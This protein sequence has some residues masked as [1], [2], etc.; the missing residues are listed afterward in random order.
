MVHIQKR[1]GVNGTDSTEFHGATPTKN[2]KNFAFG[3]IVAGELRKY[4]NIFGQT[5]DSDPTDTKKSVRKKQGHIVPALG[6][7]A[8]ICLYHLAIQ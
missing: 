1:E 7:D 8:A 3:R 5:I 2:A 4:R 6:T